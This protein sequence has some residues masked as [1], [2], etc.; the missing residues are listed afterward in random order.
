MHSGNKSRD[1]ESFTLFVDNIPEGRDQQW[2]WKTF[3]MYGVVKD[4]FIPRQR[5]KCTGNK[6]G[7]VRFDCRISAGMAVS[8][9]NGVWVDNMRLFVKE[10]CFGQDEVRL[11]QKLPSFSVPGKQAYRLQIDTY[12]VSAGSPVNFNLPVISA[13]IRIGGLKSR[14]EPTVTVRT[15]RFLKLCSSPKHG[16]KVSKEKERFGVRWSG[17]NSGL[18]FA[19]VVGGESSKTGVVKEQSPILKIHPVGNGWLERSAMAILDRVESMMTLKVSF[20]SETDKVAQFRA[21]G[22]RSVLITFQ[23]KEVRDDL[24]KGPWMKRWFQEVK[25]WR[26]EPASIERFV[27]LSCFGIPLNAWN[28]STFKQI[29]EF[30]GCFMKVDKDTLRDSSFAQGFGVT[31][32][33]GKRVVGER[34]QK[35]ASVL[36]VLQRKEEAHAGVGGPMQEDAEKQ[37]MFDKEGNKVLAEDFE[38]IDS[39][40]A[41]SGAV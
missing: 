2:L 35:F 28:T 8:K 5:S 37:L 12:R 24:I 26:R 21:L 40:V 36:A 30:W 9:L 27:W 25:P 39:F 23:S 20:S 22:G 14:Y 19:Q 6:F 34:L 3:N 17:G 31:L 15:G 33:N 10:A 18:S 32:T 16:D 7:F 41:D 1:K 13:R 4:A 11:K 29:G 38:P